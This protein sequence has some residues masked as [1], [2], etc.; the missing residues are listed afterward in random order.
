M[1]SAHGAVV[2]EDEA[3]ESRRELID[4]PVFLLPAHLP[5]LV[6]AGPPAEHWRPLATLWAEH[7]T[8]AMA[9][10]PPGAKL[11]LQAATPALEGVDV[12]AFAVFRPDRTNLT[13]HEVLGW[14]WS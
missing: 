5:A 1:G 3:G 4:F 8:D 2:H 14:L 12:D 6:D 7:S 10:A 9:V 13:G 11:K